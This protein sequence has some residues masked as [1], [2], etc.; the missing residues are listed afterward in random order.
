MFV[1]VFVLVFVFVV[2]VLIMAAP[3]G[4]VVAE[5][6]AAVTAR[7]CVAIL[8]PAASTSGA[9]GASFARAYPISIIAAPRPCALPSRV[10]PGGHSHT[11]TS[12]LKASRNCRRERPPGK[13]LKIIDS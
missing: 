2:V 5:F 8:T 6:A 9:S 1:F 11:L 10:P 12:V 13:E 4:A 7:T 3:V